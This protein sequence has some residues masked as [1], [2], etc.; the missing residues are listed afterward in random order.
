MILLADTAWAI[1]YDQ[2]H[3]SPVAI[4]FGWFQLRWYALSYVAMFVL[5]WLYLRRLIAQPGAPM[6]RDQLDDLLFHVAIG[7]I[8]GGRLGYCLFYQPEIWATPIEILKL[9]QG[10]MSLH[11]GLIGVLAALWLFA[12]RH[13]LSMLRICDYV[14]CAAPFGLFLVRIANFVNGELWGRPSNLPWAVIFPGTHDG[15]PRHPSQLY[16]AVIEGLLTMAVL[17]FLFWRTDARLRPGRLLGTGLLLYGTA[18]FLLE[19]VRQ[20][21]AG[22]EHLPWGLTMGQTL[23]APMILAGLWFLVRSRAQPVAATTA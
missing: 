23:S 21:D 11:G 14:A 22:L 5:G 8:L 3:L 9:W 12:R 18:R 20:P 15:I 10:G 19:F 13:C 4:D 1:R 7:V 17:G 6:A 16:E 2:L